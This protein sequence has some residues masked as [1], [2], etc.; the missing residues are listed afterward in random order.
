MNLFFSIKQPVIILIITFSSLLFADGSAQ[1]INYSQFPRNLQF[2]ARDIQDSASVTYAGTLTSAGY[3]SI[4]IE[5]Y[6]NNVYQ[7][8]KS[9]RLVYVTG[10]ASFSLS[11]KIRSELSEYKVKLFVKTSAVSTLVATADSLVCGDVYIIAGQSNSHPTDSYATYTN[12]YCRSFGVQT[13]NINGNTYNPADTLWGISKADGVVYAWG[14][15]YNVGVWGLRLQKLIKE[16]LGI[17]TCVINGGKGSSKIEDHLRNNFNPTDL[18]TIYGKLLY[19]VKKSGLSN[20]IKGVFWYQG[21]SNGDITWQNYLSNF[22]TLYNSWKLDYPNFKKIFLFQ[23]RPCC[24]EKY[25]SQ[26]RE[27]QRKL[28][29]IYPDIELL[30]TAGA[31]YYTGCHY[32]YNGYND[33]ADMIY[34]PLCKIFYT[35]SDTTDIRPPNIRAAYY[36][37]AQKKEIALLFYNSRVTNW[38]ADT[39]NQSMKNYFYLDG[40]IG[41][42]ST[43]VI[44]GDTLKLKLINA[45]NATKL[46]YLPTVWNH[47]D[48][49]VYEGPFLRNSRKIGALSFHDFPISNNPPTTLNITAIPEGFYNTSTGRLNITDT[50]TVLLRNNFFPY[51]IRDSSRAVIDSVSA[52]GS[53]NFYNLPSGTYYIV[54]KGRNTVETWSKS[55]GVAITAGATVSYNFNTPSQAYGNNLKLKGTKYCILSGD[56]NQDGLIDVTDNIS[57]LNDLLIFAQGLFRTD[58]N[59]DRIVDSNDISISYSNA[60]NFLGKITP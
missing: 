29:Q 46:T 21:E 36:T 13:A 12:E 49:L 6:K 35:T 28:P 57:I 32:Q 51:L 5:L 42:I 9:M 60:I 45:S 37:N 41:N 10:S 40:T 43:G 39:L 19:R 47:D 11:R 3:D 52:T 48:S 16:N 38:P 4:Y 2:F 24:S 20:N 14:G 8:R 58:V 34:R 55:G 26:L 56:I 33:L 18:T 53:F 22:Q 44:S 59:G 23:T 31:S 1:T 54:L 15:P 30:S 7:N 17:P 50:M 25:A 27:T